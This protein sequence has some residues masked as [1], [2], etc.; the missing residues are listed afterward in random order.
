[1]SLTSFSPWLFF[2]QCV[3][4]FRDFICRA[5][6][7][8]IETD[9]L[10]NSGSGCP[11]VALAEGPQGVRGVAAS[12]LHSHNQRSLSAYLFCWAGRFY[13]VKDVH[14]GVSAYPR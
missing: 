11:S 6:C 10:L 12:L 2:H 4:W 8:V 7:L 9:H 3:G 14:L 5:V 13:L 1:M